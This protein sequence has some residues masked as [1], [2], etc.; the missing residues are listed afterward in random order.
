MM[1]ARSTSR[2]DAVRGCRARM[3]QL[4][5]LR[6][7]TFTQR[8]NR[9]CHELPPRDLLS[10]LL[11]GR[12]V[13]CTTKRAAVSGI[14][15]TLFPR[16]S[17]VMSGMSLRADTVSEWRA[18]HRIT[19]PEIFDQYFMLAPGVGDIS[20]AELR[21]ILQTAQNRDV[22]AAELRGLASRRRPDQS[23]RLRAFL[24]R[25][26]HATDPEIPEEAVA[27]ALQ[28]IY[29]I[30]DELLLDNDER[31]FLDLGNEER[32]VL[33][34]VR[35]LQRIEPQEARKEL[36][37]QAV[38]DAR[39]LF[40]TTYFVAWLERRLVMPTQEDPQTHNGLGLSP[41]ILDE[42][43]QIALGAIRNA[44]EDG[45]FSKTRYLGFLL[46]R[47]KEWAARRKRKRM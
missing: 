7:L 32:L 27:P 2:A 45:R 23:S 13:G 8:T 47:L 5:D 46:H 17:D 26:R 39:A 41:P 18:E 43:K 35:L 11:W 28:V 16:W 6:L 36:L 38:A 30:G 22:F 34:T 31:G 4:L 14:L 40:M 15:G 44:A 24:E 21:T 9:Q 37:L 33:V 29:H 19:H 25:L 1:V 42:L 10:L 20:A 3:R 12:L